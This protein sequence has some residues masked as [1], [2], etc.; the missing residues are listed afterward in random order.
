MHTVSCE[1][2]RGK[3]CF[4][5]GRGGSR[6]E[7]TLVCGADAVKT[8]SCRISYS[9]EHKLTL[10]PSSP[11]PVDPGE[12]KAYVRTERETAHIS[13]SMLC[14]QNEI[15]LGHKEEQNMDASI[16]DESQKPLLREV[17]QAQRTPTE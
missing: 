9:S 8:E 10:K 7:A 4:S 14:P 6:G 5:A 15:L 1:I 11:T 3:S 13:T 17:G 12:M 2:R 16:V